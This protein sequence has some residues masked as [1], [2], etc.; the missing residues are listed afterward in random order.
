MKEKNIIESDSTDNT[1]AEIN[2]S[3]IFVN[4]PINDD[5][6]D[7]LGIKT[8]V[9]RINQAI[10]DGANIIGIIGDYG[11]GKSSLIELIKSKHK[12]SININMWGNEKKE[13]RTAQ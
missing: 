11:T 8:Y 6:Q 10:D 13:Y 2:N 4:N 9:N 12:N 1:E 5:K 3:T 7:V